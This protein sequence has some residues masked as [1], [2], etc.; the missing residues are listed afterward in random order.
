[1]LETQGDWLPARAALHPD[2]LYL[3]LRELAPAEL[4]DAF[5]AQTLARIAARERIIQV[6]REDLGKGTA[7]TEPAGLVFHVARCGSTLISQLL[8]QL[9]GLV[10]YSEPLPVTEILLPPHTWSRVELVGALRSLAAAFADHAQKAYVFKFTSWNT[11]FCDILAEAFPRSPWVLSLRDPVE[12]AVS[13]LERPPGWVWESSGPNGHFSACVDPGCVSTSREEY[14]AL[15]Y[16]AFCTA[17]SRLEASRGK[18]V[19]Y[20][21]LPAAVW[22]TVA[23]HFSLSVGAEERRAMTEAARTNA[24]APLGEAAMFTSD[25]AAKQATASAELRRAIDRFARPRLA[26]L[27]RLHGR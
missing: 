22:E 3:S 5:M 26:E 7:N 10:V 27:E 11:L 1:M 13:L 2:G 25:S 19:P 14:V 17:I 15:L 16:G 24:K 8:K 4:K 23:P 21:S 6:A 18:L 12:V 9:D 20:A